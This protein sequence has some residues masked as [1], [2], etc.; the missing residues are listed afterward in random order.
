MGGGGGLIVDQRGPQ[1]A[2]NLAV[3]LSMNTVIREVCLQECAH[4]QGK[5]WG[6]VD[7]KI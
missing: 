5:Y 2:Q 1:W 6:N 4:A 3:E 7:G